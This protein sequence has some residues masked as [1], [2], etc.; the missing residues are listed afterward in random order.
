MKEKARK[1]KTYIHNSFMFYHINSVF[2][3]QTTYTG[4]YFL[5]E[6]QEQDEQLLDVLPS[7]SVQLEGCDILDIS[8]GDIARATFEGKLYP[9]KIIGKGTAI[10]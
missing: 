8:E 6:W 5:V 4:L 1:S 10:V 2:V 3:T 7:K 9:V